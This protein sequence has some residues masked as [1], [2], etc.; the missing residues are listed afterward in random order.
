MAQE[1]APPQ[2][3]TPWTKI[4]TA[5]KV[6][7]DV[8]KLLLAATG[9]LCV[10]LGWWVIGATFYY[11]RPF[12]EWKNYENK[13]K[14][15]DVK[16]QWDNFKLNRKSWNLLHEL[17]G[18]PSAAKTEDAADVT[19][20]LDEYLILREWE[21]AY[22][23][24]ITV[25]DKVLEV[26]IHKY[27]IAELDEQA[28]KEFPRLLQEKLTIQAVGH[29]TDGKV[30][31]KAV[32][33]V[34]I[35]GVKLNIVDGD[36][37]KLR[38]LKASSNIEANRMAGMAAMK[39]FNERLRNPKVKPSGKLCNW[40]WFEE[41]GENPYLMVSG[42][43]KSPRDSLAPRGKLV[44]WL[45]TEEAPVVLEPVVKFFLPIVYFF[46]ERAGWLDRLYLV[47]ILLCTLAVWGYFGGAI[48]RIAAVQVARNERIS[49]V[50]ALAF[51]RDRCASYIAAPAL[52]L[53]LVAIFM[54]LLMIFGWLEWTPYVGDL[55][56]GLLWPIVILFG[57]IMTIVLVGLVGWPLMIATISVEGNDSFDALSRS[58][59]YVY[60]AP[61][62]YLW[63]N[64][65]AVVYGAV[66]IFFVG[67]MAS[68]MIFVGKWGVASAVGPANS[69]EKYDREPSY[70]FYYA[71]TSFGWRDLMISGNQHVVKKTELAP[72]GRP[73]HRYEFNA[74]ATKALSGWNLMGSVLVQVWIWPLFLLVVGFG[75][76]FFWSASTIIYFLMRHQVDDTDLDE[77]HMEDEELDDPFMKPAAPAAPPEAPPSKPGTL[78]LNVV[79]PPSP[80]TANRVDDIPPPPPTIPLSEDGPPSG[81]A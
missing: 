14:K 46:D 41:R 7:L 20:N 70:L 18:S 63:Y 67:F 59:S 6:A 80:T 23:L 74:E 9:I 64:F 26:S 65:L 11:L 77:V 54:F 47:C 71:P 48:C 36:I 66:L 12:P 33:T 68:M 27:T 29:L 56:A 21:E 3:K 73:V 43:I 53:I 50:E 72:S 69:D 4:F 75:Y 22:H 42:A 17:A 57:F 76:S 78:S 49:L 55:F 10:A 62:Q 34:V 25:R 30:N 44:D 13:D 81:S 52:P 8:K 19:D 31:G 40:P 24:P 38:T 61:W 35:D 5:F 58:Y 1:Q 15:D 79:E 16:A 39:V 60:Q 32:H 2:N 51:T 28:K 37:E 45:L